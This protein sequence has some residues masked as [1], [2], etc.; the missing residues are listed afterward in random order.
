MGE[1]TGTWAF[2]NTTLI[3]NNKMGRDAVGGGSMFYYSMGYK[4]AVI[5]L[6]Q[7]NCSI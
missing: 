1:E 3:R 5:I 7:N 4:G 6:M 2:W